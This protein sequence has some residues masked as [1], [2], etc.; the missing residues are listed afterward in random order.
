MISNIT[1]GTIQQI[2]SVIKGGLF[3]KINQ[4]MYDVDEDVIDEIG[5]VV[6]KK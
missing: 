4:M 2:Q 5:W 6:N 3:L 1:A